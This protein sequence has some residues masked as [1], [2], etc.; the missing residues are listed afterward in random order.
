MDCLEGASRDAEKR[1]TAPQPGADAAIY[2]R[3]MREFAAGVAIVA[4]GAG[5]NRAGCTVT[6]LSSL[7]LNPPT[8]L[9][10][11]DRKALTLARLREAGAFSV[12]LL[13]A[14]H[15]ELADLFAGRDGAHGEARFVN[16]AW[17]TLVTGA[18]LLADALAA[19]DCRV[20]EI[21]ERHSH[22]IVIGAMAGVRQ[23]E[24]GPGLAHWR[25]RYETLE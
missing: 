20:E 9:I 4:C 19:I 1:M 5:D 13:A 2:R 17:L 21:I 12:N 11:L 24:G 25:S 18:P 6:A 14:R 23:G 16:G 7:S 10:C 22:A 8:L 15:R 3:A